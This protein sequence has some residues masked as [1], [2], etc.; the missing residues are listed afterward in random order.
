M[1]RRALPVELRRSAPITLMTDI[2][3][4]SALIVDFL[5]LLASE[6]HLAAVLIA[7]LGVGIGLARLFIEPSRERDALRAAAN[8]FS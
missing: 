2:V 4:A 5:L 1:N 7:G 3:I 6:W 8:Q